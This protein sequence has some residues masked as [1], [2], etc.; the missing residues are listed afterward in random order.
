[1]DPEKALLIMRLLY[2]T[3][4]DD[5]LRKLAERTDNKYDDTLIMLLDILLK[6]K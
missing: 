3:G 4:L 1:M 6:N 2:N 5:E